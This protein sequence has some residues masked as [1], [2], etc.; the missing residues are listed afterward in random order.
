M[1]VWGVVRR[2][3]RRCPVW[4]YVPGS[5]GEPRKV[6]CDRGRHRDQHHAYGE[7]GWDT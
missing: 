1:G 6:Y 2:T 3:F 5:L 4:R 7:R